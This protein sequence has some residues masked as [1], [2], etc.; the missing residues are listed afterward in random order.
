MTVTGLGG[1][2]ALAVPTS[3]PPVAQV[4]WVARSAGPHRWKVT[5]P[6]KVDVPPT[7]TSALSS[8]CTDPVPMEIDVMAAPLLFSGV[9]LV[10]EEQLLI[11]W[12]WISMSSGF[13]VNDDPDERDS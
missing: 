3:V 10:D 13:D 2:T 9:V 11:G 5:L 12:C 4:V 8:T 1:L 7:V 6:P